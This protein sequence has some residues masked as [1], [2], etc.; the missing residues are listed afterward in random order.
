M[1]RD[2]ALDVVKSWRFAPNALPENVRLE[3]QFVFSLDVQ[4]TAG[5]PTLHVSITDYQRVEVKSE[6]YVKTIE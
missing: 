1:L 2:A 5:E 4:S 6:L 3:T